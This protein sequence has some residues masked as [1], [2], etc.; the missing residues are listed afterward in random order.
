MYQNENNARGCKA[1]TKAAN[2]DWNATN[3]INRMH[4]D[5]CDQCSLN[6]IRCVLNAME[7]ARWLT[8]SYQSSR[9]VIRWSGTTS[10]QCAIDVTT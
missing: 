8:T 10:K 2:K 3:S 1:H 6:D 9:V 5:N 7:L 4:G